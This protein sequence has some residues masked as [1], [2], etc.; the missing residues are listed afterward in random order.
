L[1]LCKQSGTGVKLFEDKVPVDTQTMNLAEELDMDATI[2]TMNGG[3][4][5]ELMFTINPDDLS[6][7]NNIPGLAVIGKM[8]D[9]SE[10][11]I[12]K[13]R[14]EGE[15]TISAQGWNAYGK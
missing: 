8:L 2:M 15:V 14:G 10:G 3:E 9:E 13:G 6:K 1:H 4:D 7:L 5:Y 11:H 12:L